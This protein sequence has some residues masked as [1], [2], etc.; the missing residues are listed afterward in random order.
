II[1]H[2]DRLPAL[3]GLVPSGTVAAA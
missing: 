1:D 3:L 2:L